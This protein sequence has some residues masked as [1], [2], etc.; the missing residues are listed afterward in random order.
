MQQVFAFR[1]YKILAFFI[2]LLFLLMITWLPV[3]AF[4]LNT[5]TSDTFSFLDKL[6]I[7]WYSLGAFRTNL[8]LGA[9]VVAVLIAFFAG[10]NISFAVYYFKKRLAAEREIG[11]SMVGMVVAFFG[12]GCSACG[13]VL[14]SSVIGLSATAAITSRLPLH[15]LEFSLLGLLIIVLSTLLIAHKMQH[16]KACKI[17]R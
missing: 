13:S 14:L 10:I 12:I 11:V 6:T 7:L 5:I 16:P 3:H 2:I 17:K 8:T 1:M 15:G 9:Q 4:V